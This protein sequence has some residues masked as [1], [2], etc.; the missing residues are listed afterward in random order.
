[1][2]KPPSTPG[3]GPRFPIVVGMEYDPSKIGVWAQAKVAELLA[4]LVRLLNEGIKP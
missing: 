2:T 1:M 3:E 4:R